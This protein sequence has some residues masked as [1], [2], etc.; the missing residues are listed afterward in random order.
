MSQRLRLADI[1]NSRAPQ[2]LNVCRDDPRIA[3]WVSAFQERALCLGRFW[4]SVQLAQFCIG[5]NG[6]VTL[7]R[8]VAVIEAANL[9]GRPVNVQNIWGQFVRPHVDIP[10]CSTW[11]NRGCGCCGCTTRTMEDHGTSASCD[12]TRDS[13][14]KLRFYP[15]GASDVGKKIIVQG[16]DRNGVWVRTTIDGIV[17][18]GEQVTLAVPFVDTVTIWGPGAPMAVIKE[19]TNYRVLVYSVNTVNAIEL[20]IADYQPSETTPMYRVVK[21][22]GMRRMTSGCGTDCTVNTLLCVVS[23]AHIPATVDS[24]FLLFTNLQAYVM[25][26]QAEKMYEENN[27]VAGDALFF[28]NNRAPRNARGVLR[29]TYGMGA[30]P[31]LQ[32]ELRKQ[33]GDRTSANIQHDAVNL[34]GFT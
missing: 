18:D 26:C 31:L 29:H 13:L 3:Q 21:I 16:N 20:P 28:G 12:T 9:N 23:L 17:S 22:P 1:G 15:G 19:V 24:D 8:E 32:A 34:I 14:Q 25:G 5:S 4:G 11:N 7:P 2:V 33:T 30:M 6:C 27:V 10:N